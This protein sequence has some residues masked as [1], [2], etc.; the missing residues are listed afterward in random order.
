MDKELSSFYL[1][2]AVVVL[3]ISLC[4]NGIGLVLLSS[5]LT[6][7]QSQIAGAYTESLPVSTIVS[8]SNQLTTA[9]P[10]GF[11]SELMAIKDELVRLRAEQHDINRILDLPVSPR[12][13]INIISNYTTS[14]G[15]ATKP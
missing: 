15:S 1:R 5:R 7:L 12:E 11:S 13:I 14:T 3:I 4:I 2:W 9:T 10:S 8:G 6:K